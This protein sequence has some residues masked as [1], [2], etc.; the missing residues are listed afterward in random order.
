MF[1]SNITLTYHTLTYHTLTYHTL[2]CSPHL[3]TK[4][5]SIAPVTFDVVSMMTLGCRLIWSICVSRAFTTLIAS[6]GSLPDITDWR[7]AVK[8]ST[9]S[10]HTAITHTHCQWHSLHTHT[11]THTHTVGVSPRQWAHT[12]VSLYRSPSPAASWTSSAPAYHST[13]TAQH[14]PAAYVRRR[15]T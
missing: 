12:P 10:R 5:R 6:D 9:W 2:S 14:T 7:A 4:A 15:K 11:H 3:S 13:A 1:P 8:L